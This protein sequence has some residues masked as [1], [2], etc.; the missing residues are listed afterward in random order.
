M[1]RINVKVNNVEGYTYIYSVEINRPEKTW[2]EVKA[3]VYSQSGVALL[4]NN[5]KQ[6]PMKIEKETIG[7]EVMQALWGK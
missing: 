3:T 4:T 1:A 5:E 2:T 7:E 6:K